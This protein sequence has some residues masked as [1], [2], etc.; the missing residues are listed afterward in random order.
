MYIL[1][2]F[3]PWKCSSHNTLSIDN[4][5]VSL[6]SVETHGYVIN[7]R[8]Y[9]WSASPINLAIADRG[10]KRR[11]GQFLKIEY[12]ENEW[13]FF[14]KIKSIFHNFLEA[15]F[16]WNTKKIADAS[17]ELIFN[18]FWYYIPD[19]GTHLWGAYISITYI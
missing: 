13:S 17:L 16:W 3:F 2:M 6:L 10:K 4:I 11:R 14:G 1:C 15:L 7:F 8:I 19:P 12:L 9:L 18:M 5:K